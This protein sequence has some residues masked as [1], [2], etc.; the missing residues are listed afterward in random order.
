M[1]DK[2][3]RCY[4]DQPNDAKTINVLIGGLKNDTSIFSQYYYKMHSI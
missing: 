4:S 2:N 1:C 3:T